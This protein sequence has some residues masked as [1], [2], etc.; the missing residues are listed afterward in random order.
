MIA[1]HTVQFTAEKYL[2]ENLNKPSVISIR[3]QMLAPPAWPKFIE[4][5]HVRC[6]QLDLAGYVRSKYALDDFIKKAAW[7]YADKYLKKM[8]KW[9]DEDEDPKPVA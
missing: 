1:K 7:A 4:L 9:A 6:N 8:L 5:L 2:R 3:D